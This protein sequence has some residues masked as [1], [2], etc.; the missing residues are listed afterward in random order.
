[1]GIAMWT[2]VWVYLNLQIGLHRIGQRTLSL[3]AH[4]GDRSLGLRPLGKLAFTGFWTF[5]SAF[6]PLVLSSA[7]NRLGIT[8]GLVVLLGGVAV[9]FLSLR[10]LNRQMVAA[11]QREVEWARHL[12]EQALQPVRKGGTLEALQH[13]AGLLSSAEAL[14][15]RAEHIQEWPFDEATFARVVTIASTVIAAILARVLLAPFGM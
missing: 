3:D 8:I 10:R 15:K 4:L 14:E 7:S 13:Q 6:A 1:M 11:K 9:F 5:I 2:F 12:Y